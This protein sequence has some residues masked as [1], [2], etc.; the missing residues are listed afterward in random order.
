MDNKSSGFQSQLGLVI[1]LIAGSVGLGN[2]WRFPRVAAMNGGG[3]FIVAW[4]IM[5]IV[6]CL[7]IMLGEHVMG[8]TTRHGTPGA[9]RDFIGKKF[10][11]MGTSVNILMFALTAYYCVLTAW[12]GH[13]LG[14]AI[15]KGYYGAD[16]AALFD[17]VSNKSIVTVLI[18]VILI[19]L[20]SFITYKGIKGIEKVTKIFLPVL[21]VCLFITA[22]R[23]LMLPGSAA[24][25]NFLFSFEPKALLSSKVWLEALTQAVWSAGPGWGLCITFAVFAK[26]KSDATLTT[27]LQVFGNSMA[28]LLAGIA[29]IPAIFAMA[30]SIADATAVCS[31]GNYGLTFISLTSLFEQMPGGYI[32]GILFF[33]SLFLAAFSSV[34]ASVMI[35]ALP[36]AD[37]GVPKKK[38]ILRV[39][40]IL[41][42]WGVPSAWSA[43]FL[44]N[45]DW[46]VGQMMV[47]GAFLSC[48]AL[49]K[50]GVKKVRQ[51]FINNPY[52]GMY[53][54]KWWEWSIKVIAPTIIVVMFFWWS[55]Q[56]ISWDPQWWNPFKALSLGTS[57][58][59][60]GLMVLVSVLFNER[61]SNSIKNKYFDGDHFPEIPDNGYNN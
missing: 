42:I 27:S 26:R 19:S 29:V 3:A 55:F 57:I 43:N 46:V 49:V 20:A 34:I 54:G 12:V 52:T 28:A 50:F 32:V 24:G 17:A 37:S 7:P 8:R 38:A 25:M 31:Q 21:F 53:M 35:V 59:Q 2:I 30:P 1:T 56:S 41:L 40:L 48:Y 60:G 44:S 13:Y 36:M 5:A 15:T 33:L 18:F 9:F 23:A 61:V 14:L 6:V 10:T 47:F 45:Q 11:W 16:K 4:A 58:V 51:T 39:Y 22:V